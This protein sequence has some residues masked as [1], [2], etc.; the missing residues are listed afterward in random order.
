VFNVHGVLATLPRRTANLTPP[1]ANGPLHGTPVPGRTDLPPPSGDRAGIPRSRVDLCTTTLVRPTS[2]TE[3]SGVSEEEKDQVMTDLLVILQKIPI[4]VIGEFRG[5][6]CACLQSPAPSSELRAPISQLPAPSSQLRAPV[7]SNSLPTVMPRRTAESLRKIPVARRPNC[8]RD[9]A[10]T[11][12]ISRQLIAPGME[13]PLRRFHPPRRARH[14]KCLC[15]SQ[16]G[17]VKVVTE[18][19]EGTVIP[20]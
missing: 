10:D 6:S 7:G 4:Q 17:P 8:D 5:S 18:D 11:A 3:H 20:L 2:G 1:L 9:S 19:A 12:L 15:S 13:S 16:S 14:A